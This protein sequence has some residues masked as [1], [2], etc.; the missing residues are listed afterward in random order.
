MSLPKAAVP[1]MRTGGLTK[2][3]SLQ[4]GCALVRVTLMSC[5]SLTSSGSGCWKGAGAGPGRGSSISVTWPQQMDFSTS[6]RDSQAEGLMGDTLDRE[7]ESVL[8][9]QSRD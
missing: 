6:G 1:G 9:Q 5:D 3:W 7:L 4:P 8:I 2:L